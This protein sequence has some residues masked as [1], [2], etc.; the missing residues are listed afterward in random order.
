MPPNGKIVAVV[1]TVW[2]I[3]GA[4]FD[5]WQRNAIKLLMLPLNLAYFGLCLGSV[6]CV[7]TYFRRWRIRAFIP[8]AFCIGAA[9]ITGTTSP[10]LMKAGFSRIMPRYAAV[11]QQIEA[12][13]IV[14]SN[15][16]VQ[17]ALKSNDAELSYAVWADRATNGILSVTFYVGGSF[18]VKHWGYLY[19]SPGD[20]PQPEW[21]RKNGWMGTRLNNNWFYI[22][23]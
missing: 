11:V 5:L 21:W 18:P 17:V 14:V 8:L 1:C 3:A 10:W 16:P 12:G 6:V 2:V 15:T 4:A 7:F 19:R 9:L 23:D 22:F 13:Q 20:D